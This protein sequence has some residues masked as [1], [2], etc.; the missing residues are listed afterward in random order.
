MGYFSVNTDIFI[1]P[2]V[3]VEHVNT[4]PA[5]MISAAGQRCSIFKILMK[6]E[7][8]IRSTAPGNTVPI[9]GAGSDSGGSG[10]LL[11]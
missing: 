1:L 9:A 2:G 7:R 5:V 8:S 3:Y 4:P 10:P 11:G 6:K